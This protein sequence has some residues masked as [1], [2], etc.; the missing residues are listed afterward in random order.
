MK[1]D[2]YRLRLTPEALAMY[3]EAARLADVSIPEWFRT[4][5]SACATDEILAHERAGVEVEPG[6]LALARVS[7]RKRAA[8]KRSGPA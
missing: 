8:L 6:A 7:A 5:A 4:R 1:T 2:S 3:R